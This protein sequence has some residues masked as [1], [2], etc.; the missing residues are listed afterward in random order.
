MNVNT[1]ALYHQQCDR[2]LEFRAAHPVTVIDV[3][4]IR[5]EYIVSGPPRETLLLLHGSLRIAETAF[6]YV[7]LFEDTYRVIT[8]TYPRVMQIDEMLAGI[9]AILDAEQAPSACVLGHS[10]G[11]ILAQALIQRYPERVKRL[12]LSSTRALVAPARYERLGLALV[13][14]L[15]LLPEWLILKFYRWAASALLAVPTEEQAFWKIYLDEIFA[16]RLRKVDFVSIYRTIEDALVKYGIPTSQHSSWKGKM[17]VIDGEGDQVNTAQEH[18]KL[19]TFYPQAHAIR[20][21]SGG[22]AI[23]LKQPQVYATAIKEFLRE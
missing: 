18:A 23:A 2:L 3:A 10:Y 21:A 8:P 12:A 4:G 5:W 6:V 11:G 9:V 7:Q 13:R 14:Q 22:H 15:L 19:T 16:R 20:V 1:G 17:L